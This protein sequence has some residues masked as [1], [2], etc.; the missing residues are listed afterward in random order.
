MQTRIPP[1]PGRPPKRIQIERPHLAE[2]VEQF[3]KQ[4]EWLDDEREDV[5]TTKE[6]AERVSLQVAWLGV[7]KDEFVS[8]KHSLGE[9]FA[10]AYALWLSRDRPKLRQAVT[11]GAASK[12][13]RTG[14]P[15]PFLLRLMNYPIGDEKEGRRKRSHQLSRDAKAIDYLAANGLSPTEVCRALGPSGDGSLDRWSKGG[16]TKPRR[17]SARATIPAA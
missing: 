16:S 8:G 4:F 2:E 9:Q 11:R 10:L 15:Q 6:F 1:V 5:R 13:R 14:G 17:T 3:L 7:R 12:H